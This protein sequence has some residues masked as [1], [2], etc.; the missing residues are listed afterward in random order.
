MV[1]GGSGMN[2]IPL[3]T[4]DLPPLDALLPRLEHIYATKRASNFGGLVVELEERLSRELG[5]YVVTT[6]NATLALELC[7]T[8]L[9]LPPGSE[10]ACPALTFPASATAICRAG[11]TPYF[12]DVDADSWCSAANQFPLG[13]G[14]RNAVLAVA[15]FGAGLGEVQLTGLGLPVVLDAAAAWGN[16]RAFPGVLTCFSLHATKGLIAGEGGAIAVHDKRIA[17]RLRALTNFGIGTGVVGT[18]AKMSEY[19]AAVALASLDTWPERSRKRQDAAFDYRHLLFD[20]A[21]TWQA[22]KDEWTR[23]IFPVLL[24]KGRDPEKVAVYLGARDIETRRWYYPL[25]CDSYRFSE[26]RRWDVPVSRAISARLL[27]LP[28]FTGITTEQM[29]RVA[30]ELRAALSAA[31]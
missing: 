10:V 4:P 27:G 23:T 19:H 2:R 28:F 6:A 17:D 30:K 18:N 3:L 1:Q 7:L 31:P 21:L 15:A 8:A 13:A 11:H 25:V 16:Q 5:C 14:V 9:E 20:L 22:W 26:H 29:E 12:V 24:P